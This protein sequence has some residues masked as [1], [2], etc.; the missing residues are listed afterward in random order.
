MQVILAVTDLERSLAFYESAFDW[1]RNA[2]IDYANYVELHPPDGG[3]V[4][5]YEREG[6]AQTVGAEPA[7]TVEG[8]VAPAYVYVRVA[9]VDESVT[10]LKAAG[11]RSLSPLRPRDW[12]ETAA[13]FADPDGNVI[14]VAGPSPEPSTGRKSVLL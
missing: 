3:T 12:G 9:D 10:R 2:R 8:K 4:G 5:L 6:Y 7:P 11:G 14:A 1:P 13:W